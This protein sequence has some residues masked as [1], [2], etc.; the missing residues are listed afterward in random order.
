[1][2]KLSQLRLLKEMVISKQ[3]ALH[4]ITTHAAMQH[5]VYGPIPFQ[6][7]V[8]QMEYMDALISG[9]NIILK[10]ERQTDTTLI[11][12]M[13]IFYYAMFNSDKTILLTANKQDLAVDNLNRI[14]YAFDNLHDTMKGGLKIKYTSKTEIGFNNG[15]RIQA[16]GISPSVGR[17]MTIDLLYIENFELVNPQLQ[18]EF[19]ESCVPTI[20]TGGR[21]IITSTSAGQGSTLFNRMYDAA[22]EG[23]SG[24]T[25]VRIVERYTIPLPKKSINQT[26]FNIPDIKTDSD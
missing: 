18:N 16:R 4:Y 13:Y 21:C 17:G 15:T 11:T 5:P 3:D 19:W 25:P 22:I 10:G 12:M 20:V 2:N 7:K 14:R 23:I 1:M 6:P 9:E 26:I 24:F 8:F